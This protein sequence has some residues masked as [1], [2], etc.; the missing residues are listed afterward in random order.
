[1]KARRVAPP[2]DPSGRD[3]IG[4]NLGE[5][6]RLSDAGAATMTDRRSR[7]QRSGDGAGMMTDQA[8]PG[9]LLRGR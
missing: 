3:K 8:S 9:S 2:P 7:Q 4:H 5:Q 6:R 1:M